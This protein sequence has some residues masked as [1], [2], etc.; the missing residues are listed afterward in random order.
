MKKYFYAFFLLFSL[1]II[2]CGNDDDA[3]YSIVGTWQARSKWYEGAWLKSKDQPVHVFEKDGTYL[4]YFNKDDY[5]KGQVF[6]G[7]KRYEFDGKRL[8][9]D[10]G[11]KYEVT[12][13]DDGYEVTWADNYIMFRI[14]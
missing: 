10:G 3:N 13:S 14:K 9:I 11:T 12:F 8:S 4:Y 7:K 5:E 6:G 2:S 1:F